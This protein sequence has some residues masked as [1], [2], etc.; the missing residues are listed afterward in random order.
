M[1]RIYLA[2]ALFLV[3]QIYGSAKKK[4]KY[5]TKEIKD[6]MTDNAW[7]VIRNY[8]ETFTI[9]SMNSASLSMKY[10][11][12]ILDKNGDHYAVLKESYD[13]L[14]KIKDINATIYDKNGE[15][16][17]KVK[18]SDIKDYSAVSGY[19]LF[20]DNRLKY[21]KPVVKSYPYTIEYE[22]MFDYIG[23]FN[24]PTWQPVQGYDLAVEHSSF[25]IIAPRNLSF[26]YDETNIK[27]SV[28]IY[29]ENSNKVYYW[30][31]SNIP[32]IEKEDYSPYLFEFTPVVYTAPNSFKVEGYKGNM[33]SWK[34]FGLWVNQLNKGR[35]ILTEKTKNEL[36]SLVAEKTDKH[37]I[38]RAVYK[39]LQ[40]R[41]RYVSI[42]EGIGGWQPFPAEVV[43]RTG[44]GDC[45]A[46]TNYTYA[47]LKHVGVKSYYTK[48][49][50][51]RNAPNFRKDFVSNQSNHVFLCVPID[52]DTIW[53][54]CT[55]QT[56]P[57]GYIGCF[58]D[59]RDVVVIIE[60]GGKIVHSKV[61]PQEKNTQVCIAQVAF[62]GENACTVKVSIIY[63]GLQYSNV[64][65][66][67]YESFEDQEKWLYKTIDLTN[68]NI[69]QFSFDH[70]SDDGPK[71]RLQF[72]I[73]IKN[74]ASC[75]GKRIFLPLN[76]LNRLDYVPP[77][78]S[79]RKTNVVL[80][81]PFVD[82]D[83]IRFVLP[84]GYAI[85]S[86]PENFKY[87]TIFGEYKADIEVHDRNVI[88]VRKR[89][90][91][92][93]VFPAESYDKLRM[94]YKNVSKADKTKLVLV[95]CQQ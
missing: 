64:S 95:S 20:E 88:Y 11:I 58:T 49:R 63:S 73:D 76:L 33:K 85:E 35:D 34:E 13:K 29:Q 59:D 90:M 50:A 91:N 84:E 36:D 70:I 82:I 89:K 2:L 72:N 71:A 66:I 23:L 65:G 79:D 15:L 38:T 51:G 9:Y 53:L 74:Y 12:T 41:T 39:Y 10:A 22:F 77:I 94:F 28:Q 62:N 93:G 40:S 83:S 17:E 5:D 68:F 45:K 19:S 78:N 7:A 31:V 69:T 21:Y 67:L 48:V 25:K 47:L 26:R 3:C 32:A 87:K 52:T 81:F 80:N 60:N 46:L 14:L 54:E 27:D 37:E 57:F 4:P 92:K 1:Y 42:Q 30:E 86:L 16:I 44:Y 6:E 8:E 43:D 61:Y 55:N 75:T 56:N 18:K 24:F